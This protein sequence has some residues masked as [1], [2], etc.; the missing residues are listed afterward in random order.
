MLAAGRSTRFGDADK[1][2]APLGAK[3]V[4]AHTLDT[5]LPLVDTPDEIVVCVSENN[6][7]LTHYLHA[8]HQPCVVSP[9]A[10]Q[11]MGS[12]LADA[13]IA[14]SHWPGWIVCLGDMPWIQSSTYLSL[15][16]QAA[17]HAL[18]A[19]Q[20]QGQRGHPVCFHR[21]W[22]PWLSQMQGDQGA[23]QLLAQHTDQ[24]AL[25]SVDDPG[26]TLDIDTPSDLNRRL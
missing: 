6:P 8:R 1:L 3:P 2:L 7:A 15:R 20:W 19:P 24:L 22:Y 13:I 21:Q 18:L 16:T 9:R 26:I 17:A 11:G 10:A 5:L 14:C 23:R 25:L 4:I 12:S